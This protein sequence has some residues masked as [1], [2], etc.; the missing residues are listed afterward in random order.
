MWKLKIAEGKGPYLFSTNNFVGRQFWEFDPDAGTEEERQ[1]VENV[2]QHYDKNRKL[3]PSADL[4]MQMQLVKE[5]GMEELLRIPPARLGEKEA[6]N[7]EA[8]T[9]AVRKGLR[10]L[11]ALQGADGHWPAE[12]AGPQFFT[13]PLLISLYISGAIDTILTKQHKKEMIRYLYNHQNEDGGWGFYSGG[14]STMLGTALNYVSLRLLGEAAG[15]GAIARGQ[16]WILDHGGAM[17]IPSWGKIYFSVLGVYEW[18]GCN[19]LPPEF[20]LFPEA[21]PFHPGKMWC[22]CR[23]AYMPMSYLY[24]KKFHGTITD[25][26]LS[27]RD[28]IY[29]LPYSEINWNAQRHYCCQ[30]DLYYPHTIVQDL[31]WNSLHYVTEPIMKCWPFTKLRERA[32]K[33]A[34]ELMRYEAEETRYITIGCVSKSLQMMCWWAEKPNGDEF[35]HH[36]ARV[37]EYLWMAEDGMKMQTFG[38]QVWDCTFATLAILATDM[39]EEYGDSLKR[40]HFYIKESQIRENK[41][42]DYSSMCQ[43]LSKGA[44]AWSDQDNGWPVSDCTA[45]SITCLMSLSELPK[46]MVGETV[47]TE[48]L[49]EAV[50]TLLHV[51]NHQTGGF[52]VWE[53]PI[54]NQMLQMLNPSE[55]FADIV[56]E[57][58]HVEV[59]ACI[60][61]ALINFKRRYP[62]YREKEIQVSVA[63]AIRYLEEN[64]GADGSWYGFWGVCFIYGTFFALRGLSSAGMTY[65]NSQ[66]VRKGVKFLLSTQTEEG[67]WAESRQS[68][69]KQ[70]YVQADANKMNYVQIAWAMLGL[71]YGGQAERDP[72]PLHKAAKLLINGQMNNGDFPHQEANGCFMKNC[73]QTYP[74]YR[75]YFTLWAL[76][77]YRKQVWLQ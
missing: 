68:N 35:K 11:R 14:H 74:L 5:N 64:Q 54:A 67:G 20:W 19:P 36:L 8:V 65:D 17:G 56:I 10:M 15:N 30:E 72:T 18:E 32:V 21:F 48:R 25:L 70:I 53:P 43:V 57:R 28:E 61:D 76:G 37:P 47:D 69:P 4:L 16:N 52:G 59:T 50:N 33:R 26:V 63:R 12:T 27:L 2:C 75:N 73:F 22:Y 44:W 49:Y 39:V 38:S 24:A 29:P 13:P 55:V 1:A 42:G 46:G 23:T 6:V 62:R 40:A 31:L 9:T 58:E 51:Q 7:I 3:M 77:E 41:C 60:I 45:L 34:V 66:A 71:M